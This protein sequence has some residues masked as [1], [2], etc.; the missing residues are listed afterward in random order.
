[1]GKNNWTALHLAVSSYKYSEC[2]KLLE[3]NSNLFARNSDGRLPRYITNNFF[4]TKMLY[5]KEY[6]YYYN[7]L[8]NKRIKKNINN[9]NSKLDKTNKISVTTDNY[10]SYKINNKINSLNYKKSEQNLLTDIDKYSLVEKYKYIMMLSL[11]DNKDEVEFKCKEILLKIDLNKRNN[12][13]IISDILSI[14]SKYNLTKLLPDLKRIKNKLDEKNSYL[15]FDFNSVI[16]Y[17]EQVKN[18]KI[19]I[20]T[21]INI[22]IN[23]SN[24]DD[25]G[26]HYNNRYQTSINQ[27]NKSQANKMLLKRP[28]TINEMKGG[29]IGEEEINCVK[30]IREK[31]MNN[32]AHKK[33][34]VSNNNKKMCSSGFK[35]LQEKNIQESGN[36][37][38]FELDE[39]IKN[40]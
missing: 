27:S 29:K 6:E 17:L 9:K 8:F 1:M 24:S 7:K 12:F 40:V 39:T 3:L 18:G 36:S 10:Y 34:Y 33:S 37:V 32:T 35:K 2:I 22:Y 5:K 19:N 38:D 11:N 30:S 23:H 21:K 31:L 28:G 26:T 16:K 20:I 15:K 13:I 4:L 25:E 14:I